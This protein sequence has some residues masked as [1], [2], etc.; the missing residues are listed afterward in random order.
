MDL[1]T[2]NARSIVEVRPRHANRLLMQVCGPTVY[3]GLHVGHA[4]T[5]IFFDVLARV[6]RYSGYDVD[7]ALNFTDVDEDVFRRAKREGLSSQRISDR[8]CAR[9][10]ETL[11]RL[12]ITTPNHYPRSSEYIQ[13]SVETVKMLLAKGLAYEINGH[14]FLDFDRL[15]NVG[16]VS[17]LSREKLLDIRL[18]SYAGKKSPLDFL[19]WFKC[20]ERPYWD[21]PWGPGRPGWHLQDVVMAEDIFRGPHDLHGGAVELVYPHHDCLECLGVAVEQVKPYVPYWVHTCILMVEGK[22]M[23]KSEGNLIYVDE[24]LEKYSPESLRTYFFSMNREMAV[25][26][27]L[28]E[29][30]RFE[31]MVKNI[32]VIA[33][34]TKGNISKPNE[35]FLNLKD[36]FFK[37]LLHNMNTV[38]ALD[39]FLEA[40]GLAAKEGIQL[41]ILFDM[42]EVLGL[43]NLLNA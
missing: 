25:D 39:L 35:N 40:V 15:D 17:G 43:E 14:I 6:L 7:F 16:P 24:L 29:L 8:F 41:R 33:H 4:R 2:T 32:Q 37:S 10:L 31:G 13:K 30:H 26:F 3:D 12:N 23:S 42:F 38:E 28:E 9:T 36:K 11:D 19:L 21:S 5:F 22:K 34:K 27:D 20:Q 1:Y 18:D